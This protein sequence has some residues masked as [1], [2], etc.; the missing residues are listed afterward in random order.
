MLPFITAITCPP[1][2]APSN[3]SVTYSSIADDNDSYAFEVVAT[4]SC[5]TGF[6]LVGDN[7]RTCTGDGSSTTGAF[8]GISP[9]CEGII[10]IIGNI[11][12]LWLCSCISA[13]AITCPPLSKPTNGSVSYSNVPGQ[14][15]TY[16]FNVMATYSC[17]TGFSLVDN[18]TRTC[19]GD[20][21]ST[22]GAFYG[23]ATHCEGECMKNIKPYSIL[24]YIYT[25]I[26]CPSLNAPANGTVIYNVDLEFGTLA[27]YSCDTGFSLLGN[28]S[29]TCTG[30]GSNTTGAFDGEVPTCE[31]EYPIYIL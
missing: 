20:G 10:I 28:S 26:T 19:T 9:I 30:D 5:F 8:D 17:D 31:G 22:A 13:T 25:V 21:S 16:A 14:S 7:S 29:R 2:T 27:V 6:A 4:Y 24:L 23:E 3:G 11:H 15:N 1:S 12:E 18:N